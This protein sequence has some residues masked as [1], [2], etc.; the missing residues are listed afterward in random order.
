MS[1][2]RYQASTVELTSP[3]VIRNHNNTASAHIPG[4]TPAAQEIAAAVSALSSAHNLSA[5][6]IAKVIPNKGYSFASQE[7]HHDGFASV[8]RASQQHTKGPSI[9]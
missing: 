5:D 7:A 1:V 4:N 3:L 2:S 6:A 9:T 8:V